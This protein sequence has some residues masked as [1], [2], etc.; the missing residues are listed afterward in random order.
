M[1]SLLAKSRNMRLPI[2]LQFDLFKKLVKPILLYGCE[3]W[4]FGNI[5]VLEEYSSNS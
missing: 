1:Y 5:D 3:V 4:G 2:D